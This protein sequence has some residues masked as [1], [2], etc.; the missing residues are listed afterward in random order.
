MMAESSN[1][2]FDKS[3]NTRMENQYE[4]LSLSSSE[5]APNFSWE[6]LLNPMPIVLVIGYLIVISNLSFI[7]K[8]EEDMNR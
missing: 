7:E 1:E 6:D 5:Y 4:L 8:C 3:M 2:K